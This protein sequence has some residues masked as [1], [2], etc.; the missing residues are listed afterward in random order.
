[1]SKF[2]AQT[3][4]TA[5]VAHMYGLTD[6]RTDELRYVGFTINSLEDRLR[7]HLGDARK[8]KE[9][10]KKRHVISWITQLLR[11]GSKPEIFLIET[12]PFEEWKE[13]EI[14][15][16]AYFKSLGCRLTNLTQGGDGVVG[17]TEEMK[18]R[19]SKA[20]LGV[21]RSV[22]TKEKQSQL[23]K[24]FYEEGGRPWNVGIAP[25][26]CT[27]EKIRIANLGKTYS[28]EVNL[29]KGSGWRGKK[30]GTMSEEQ[31]NKVSQAKKGKKLRMTQEQIQV[32]NAKAWATRRANGTDKHTEATKLKI[33]LTKRSK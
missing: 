18:R 6:P 28:D 7:G 15:W 5:T 30:R 9:K 22:R 19:V 8:D 2:R 16:V 1:M 24:Q 11:F 20:H 33:S 14:F 23:K 4:E 32:R 27:K 21:K 29:T 31:R 3:L 26:A 13:S 17:W 25:S 10:K 12:V